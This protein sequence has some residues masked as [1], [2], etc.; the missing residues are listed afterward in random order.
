M[1]H[2]ISDVEFTRLPT[3]NKIE[4][5]RKLFDC[6]MPIFMGLPVV[7]DV[8]RY[9]AAELWADGSKAI[10]AQPDTPRN[11]TI[12]LTDADNSCRGTLTI[13]GEDCDGETI[14]EVL[15]PN[16]TVGAKTLVGTKVFAKITTMVIANASGATPVDDVVDVGCG[17]K[18]G[19]PYSIPSSQSVRHVFFGATRVPDAVV[20]TGA[21]AG[22]IDITAS[23]TMDGATALWAFVQPARRFVE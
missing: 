5:L 11:I 9:L 1:E 21:S 12:A 10:L 17:N 22:S 14:T 7:A 15:T 13:T 16:G 19:L 4:F 23:Q 20:Y 8:N 6:S 18:I 3:A 2:T